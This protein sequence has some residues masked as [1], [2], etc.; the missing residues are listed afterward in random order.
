[1]LSLIHKPVPRSR[2]AD[3]FFLGLF[4]ASSYKF[5]VSLYPHFT[6]FLSVCPIFVSASA[7]WLVGCCLT[8]GPGLVPLILV[9]SSLVLSRFL[10]QF[11]PSTSQ[12]CLLLAIYCSSFGPIKCLRQTRQNNNTSLHN[13]ANATQLHIAKIIFHGINKCNT[14]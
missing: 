5:P 9:H 7:I 12:S 13:E 2:H 14:C 8:L 11:F 10:L 3:I 4:L 6:S 1:M